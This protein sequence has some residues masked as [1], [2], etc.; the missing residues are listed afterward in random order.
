MSTLA[1]EPCRHVATNKGATG[2][3]FDDVI[4]KS[5]ETPILGELMTRQNNQVQT[6]G[7]DPDNIGWL[8]PALYTQGVPGHVTAAGLTIMSMI[9]ID[10]EDEFEMSLCKTGD[11]GNAT[12]ADSEIDDLLSYGIVRATI[13][14]V[15]AWC[16]DKAETT[17]I[18]VRVIKRLSE[19]T[20][21][22]P[23]LLVKFLGPV[24][25]RA[26]VPFANVQSGGF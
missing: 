26:A 25:T 4:I 11:E 16:V 23:R 2:P 15:T 14:S 12:L 20:D 19:A 3:G 17:K 13:S 8:C 18:R 24:I 1:L 10:P 9:A 6:C 7:S 22:H 5:G 21:V